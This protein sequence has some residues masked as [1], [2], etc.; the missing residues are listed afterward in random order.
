MMTLLPCIILLQ[1]TL[2]EL[3]EAAVCVLKVVTGVVKDMN[4]TP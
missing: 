1:R 2:V 4:G 3:W